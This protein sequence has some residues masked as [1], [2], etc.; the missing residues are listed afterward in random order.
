MVKYI[1]YWY[2]DGEETLFSYN[3]PESGVMY[4]ERIVSPIG[5]PDSRDVS[6]RTSN[7]QILYNDIEHIPLNDHIIEKYLKEVNNNGSKI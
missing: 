4:L 6:I 3:T 7:G 5:I 1:T 2:K